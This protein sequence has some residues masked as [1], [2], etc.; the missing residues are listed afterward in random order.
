M[1]GRTVSVYGHSLGAALASLFTAELWT[2]D[3]ALYSPGFLKQVTFGEPRTFES[4][5][6]DRYQ[7]AIDKDRW[8]NWGDPVPSLPPAILDFNHFG[9]AFEIYTHWAGSFFYL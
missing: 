6:A 9:S 8:T 1:L 3:A 2:V 5:D 4:E 7:A